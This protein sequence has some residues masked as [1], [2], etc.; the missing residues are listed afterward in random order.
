MIKKGSNMENLKDE[1][2][3]NYF[4][5]N[6]NS[7]YARNYR[8]A[9]KTEQDRVKCQDAF[10]CFL[11]KNLSAANYSRAIRYVN[12]LFKKSNN[13][14]DIWNQIFYF[15]GLEKKKCYFNRVD[16]MESN[17]T[18]YRELAK[19][20]FV[21]IIKQ[22]KELNDF[23]DIVNDSGGMF[24]LIVGMKTDMIPI[25]EISKILQFD[26]NSNKGEEFENRIGEIIL[27]ERNNNE[28]IKK[29]VEEVFREYGI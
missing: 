5:K 6:S 25:D 19:I 22:G 28:C 11:D 12:E 17:I 23:A 4:L 21:F 20:L 14:M 8:K 10:L 1:I 27:D 24:E 18:K 13:I 9:K 16:F 26:V 29:L 7:I 2:L 15:T 3:E